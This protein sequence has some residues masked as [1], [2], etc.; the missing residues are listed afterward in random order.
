M[1]S[2]LQAT[3]K[4]QQQINRFL[5]HETIKPIKTKSQNET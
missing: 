1:N 2:Q 4:K 5:H 3:H